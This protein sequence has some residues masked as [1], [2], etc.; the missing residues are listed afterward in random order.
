MNEGFE[1]RKVVR[2]AAYN[3]YISIRS[4]FRVS[5]WLLTGNQQAPIARD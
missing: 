3:F 4:R 2:L 5:S 1:I